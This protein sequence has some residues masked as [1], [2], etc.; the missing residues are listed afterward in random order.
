MRKIELSD[1]GYAL[2]DEKI[3]AV[4]NAVNKGIVHHVLADQS[5]CEARRYLQELKE[6]LNEVCL[7]VQDASGPQGPNAA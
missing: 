6:T 3:Q 5:L 4:T 2:I 7:L 1:D